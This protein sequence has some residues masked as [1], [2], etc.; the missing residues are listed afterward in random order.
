MAATRAAYRAFYEPGVQTDPVDIDGEFS[1]FDYRRLRYRMNWAFYENDVYRNIHDWANAYK[2]TYGL[3]KY[4]R[5]IYNPTY[6][7]GE[8]W[9]AHLWGGPLD[10]SM[11]GEP[12]MSALPILTNNEM[13]TPA[14]A[15]LWQ[16]SNWQI[17][18]DVVA[19]YGTILGD[20]GLMVV[21]DVLRGKVYLKMIHPSIIQNLTLDDFGNV[22]GYVIQEERLSPINDNQTVTYTEIAE[23]DGDNVIYRTFLNGNLYAWNGDVNEWIEPY[24]F[25]PLVMIQHN[26]VGLDWGWSELHAAR[27]KVHEVDDQASLLN[28]QIRKTIRA[29]WFAAG[30]SKPASSP[31]ASETDLTGEAA[32]RR[33]QPGR[34]EEDIFYAPDPNSK[35][36]PFV[37][38]INIKDTLDNIKATIQELEREYPELR[39]DIFNAAGDTSGRALRIAR[40]PVED[41][42]IQRRASYDNALVRAQ[43]MAVAIGGFR[44]YDGF[45]GFDLDSFGAG[46]L[47]HAIGERPVFRM[48]PLDEM[49]L[50]IKRLDLEMRRAVLER[51]RALGGG[52]MIDNA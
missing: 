7:I 33:P 52:E 38:P 9:K 28:D 42:A 44:G 15:R 18:K 11:D 1:D 47:D 5:N 10:F 29:K 20:V 25:I 41:K 3:Y 46:D 12:A 16:W 22:K 19:L 37:A 17:N 51:E 14:I 6:R 24:G 50:E 26:N 39:M 8:F 30:L 4:I 27:S 21:D 23:R 13:L 40:Q 45:G 31:T 48:D 36:F 34:E 32:V 2:T 43:Q 35:I 49:D